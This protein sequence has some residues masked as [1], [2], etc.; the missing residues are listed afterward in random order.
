VNNQRLLLAQSGKNIP[1]LDGIRGFA[2]SFVLFYHFFPKTTSIS[3]DSFLFKIW[4]RFWLMG[5]SGVDLFFV[6]SG[7]LIT[8]ILFKTRQ[9]KNY[10]KN[11][12]IRRFLRIFPLYYLMILLSIIFIK[13]H[14]VSA[15][16]WLYASNFDVELNIPFHPVLCVAWS[17]SIEEQYYLIYPTVVYYL[18]DFQWIRFLFGLIILSFSLRLIGH[19]FGFFEPRQMYHNTL[20]HFDGIALGGLLRMM[21][22]NYDKY[23]NVIRWYLRLLPIIFILTAG[24]A[25]YCGSE[26]LEGFEQNNGLGLVSFFPPM[27]LFGY[28]LNSLSYG[29]IILFCLFYDSWALKFFSSKVMRSIGKYSYAMYLLQYPA[30]MI[31][32]FLIPYIHPITHPYNG[33]LHG[34]IIYLITYF[35]ANISW[36]VFEGPLNGLK[37]RFAPSSGH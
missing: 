5:W 23:K 12:Y 36:L 3:N 27:Y 13:G 7:F 19:Y 20:L 30:A 6:L 4:D 17:L 37:D 10:F 25:Y 14:E 29:G 26:I 31:F 11:F 33:I 24:L 8:G 15:W 9:N 28:L 1:F 34:I 21:L 22:F 16:Y 18:K 35:M 2:V 32:G